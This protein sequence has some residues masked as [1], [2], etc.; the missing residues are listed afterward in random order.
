MSRNSDFI[1]RGYE[2]YPEAAVAVSTFQWELIRRLESVFDARK[3][4]GRFAPN[5]RGRGKGSG[6]DLKDGWWISVSQSGLLS[7]E[8]AAVEIGYLWDPPF[9]DRKPVLFCK[10]LTDPARLLQFEYD[11]SVAEVNAVLQPSWESTVLISPMPK[12][13]DPRRLIGLQL[14]VLVK[15]MDG[16]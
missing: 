5:K 15:V 8:R 11:G 3:A 16:A 14:D 2:L 4:W 13:L 6:G 12:D 9:D 7:D 1:E 10:F